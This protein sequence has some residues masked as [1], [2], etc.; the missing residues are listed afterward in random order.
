[1]PVIDSVYCHLFNGGATFEVIDEGQGP[2]IRISSE[3]FGNMQTEFKLLTDTESLRTI[4]AMLIRASL[5]S[6]YSKEYCHLA[7]SHRE[8]HYSTGSS[9][10]DDSSEVPPL[11][12]LKSADP[13]IS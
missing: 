4:G 1:M 10:A 7:T 12:V 11:L 13:E 2:T 8:L 5:K 9:E 6:G 3:V